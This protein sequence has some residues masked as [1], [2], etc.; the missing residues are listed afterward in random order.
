MKS[1]MIIITAATLFTTTTL[2]LA[3]QP[4]M[5]AALSALQNA[6]ASLQRATDDKGGH[7][8]KALDHINKAINQVEAGIK[9]DNKHV[10]KKE[11]SKD[12]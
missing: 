5:Q 2:A 4:N 12:R 3:D 9:Y 1:L 6:K 10:S 8:A 11:K 7:K